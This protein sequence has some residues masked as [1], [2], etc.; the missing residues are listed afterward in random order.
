MIENKK[1]IRINEDNLIIDDYKSIRDDIL[2]EMKV[3]FN[4]R[5]EQGQLIN[6]PYNSADY[7][8]ANNIALALW[9]M[10]NGIKDVFNQHNLDYASGRFL[11][12]IMS[13]YGAYRIPSKRYIIECELE[14]LGSEAHREYFNMDEMLLDSNSNKYSFK[15][16]SILENKNN[17]TKYLLEAD[18][19]YE[20]LTFDKIKNM[21]LRT[22][23]GVIN[24]VPGSIK[25]I[26]AQRFKESDLMFKARVRNN[27]NY[28]ILL[29]QLQAIEYVEKIRIIQANHKFKNQTLKTNLRVLQVGEVAI[30]VQLANKFY[31]LPVEYQK[32]T[33]RN[34]QITISEFLNIGLIS[35][36]IKQP[37]QVVDWIESKSKIT[38]LTDLIDQTIIYN[39]VKATY[40]AIFF[41]VENE[42]NLESLK[43]KVE[44]LINNL[45][46]EDIF[47][48]YNKNALLTYLNIDFRVNWEKLYIYSS[49]QNQIENITWNALSG[50]DYFYDKKHIELTIPNAQYNVNNW[51]EINDTNEQ[52]YKSFTF[53]NYD[54][55]YN[56]QDM[57]FSVVIY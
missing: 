41:K 1:F 31:N 30:L 51:R 14:S 28:R 18:E 5:D 45:N 7:I 26:V 13:Y 43:S 2:E 39:E 34:I 49:E 15:F 57:S 20:D 37:G 21:S 11:N 33:E 48:N 46:S 54:I 6:I 40:G 17:S 55:K 47:F 25:I 19:I 50:N 23:D 10:A 16:H 12:K 24:S 4:Y 29:E 8:F 32:L 53:S 38:D 27:S 3:I 35:S 56:P 9:N 42:E 52:I 36:E 22:G 44:Q